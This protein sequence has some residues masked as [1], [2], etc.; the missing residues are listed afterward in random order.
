MNK[1][2]EKQKHNIERYVKYVKKIR[3]YQD[4]LSQTLGIEPEGKLFNKM[5][6]MDGLAN[7]FLLELTDEYIIDWVNWFIWENDFGE[8]EMKAGEKGNSKPIKNLD[9]LFECINIDRT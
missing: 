8:K 1:L 9:N 7:D 2:T 3:E 6:L 4:E 5:W